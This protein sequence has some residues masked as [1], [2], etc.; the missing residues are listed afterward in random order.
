MLLALLLAAAPDTIYFN[1]KIITMWRKTPVV[2]AIAVTGDRFSAAGS[3]A[4]VLA[5][6]GLETLKINLNGHVVTPGLIDSHTHPIS[7]AL[8]EQSDPIPVWNNI[9]D[10]Q[11]YLRDQAAKTPPE[12]PIIALKVYST[13][14]AERRYPTRYELDAA[15]PDRPAMTDN[16]YASVLNSFLLKKLN[17]TRDTP[18]PAN[19]KIIKDVRGEPTGLVLGASHILGPLRRAQKPSA[20]DNEWALA[21]MQKAFNKAGLTSVIDRGQGPEGFRAYQNSPFNH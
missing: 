4:D 3:T 19:G 15:A 17:I 16:S 13:R 2:Q 18:Q 5:L 6:A 1:G 12:R 14:L 21:A 9:K 11:N 7:S 8:S 10:I 20:A